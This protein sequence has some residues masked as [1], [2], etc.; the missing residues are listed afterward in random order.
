[1]QF[2]QVKGAWKAVSKEAKV[3]MHNHQAYK[4]STSLSLFAVG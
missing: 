3:W 4:I 2:M 1:M